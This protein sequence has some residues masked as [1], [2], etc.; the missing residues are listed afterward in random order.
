M[1]LREQKLR[2]EQKERKNKKTGASIY[3]VQQLMKRNAI[4]REPAEGRNLLHI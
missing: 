3:S 4:D 2:H 1:F